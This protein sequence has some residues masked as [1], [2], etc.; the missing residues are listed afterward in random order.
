MRVFDSAR[1][2][3][4]L[5]ALVITIGLTAAPVAAQGRGRGRAS[6]I[7]PGQ[8]PPAGLCRVWYEGVPPGQ[9][10]RP[11]DCRQA[12]RVAARDRYAQVI[13][14]NTSWGGRDD[15]DWGRDDRYSSRDAYWD[16]APY[17]RQ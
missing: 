13:Y 4:T 8:L 16:P 2:V 11:M 6:G 17:Y 9:Q 14:G 10:P 12:E 3:A 7:P 1:A 5:T 15:R